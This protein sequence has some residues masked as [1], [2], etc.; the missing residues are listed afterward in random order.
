MSSV[1]FC[2]FLCIFTL[3]LSLSQS[4]S[5]CLGD[6]GSFCRLSRS[7][8]VFPF[9]AHFPKLSR[10]NSL[11]LTRPTPCLPVVSNLSCGSCCHAFIEGVVH[12]GCV[13][14]TTY[15]FRFVVLQF[16]VLLRVVLG[17]VARI[18]RKYRKSHESDSQHN[19]T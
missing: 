15:P 10:R 14:V 18:N 4:V 1:L 7:T 3:F 19:I 13:T 2:V 8:S 17:K 5:L 11:R 6:C 12:L 16:V 9:I